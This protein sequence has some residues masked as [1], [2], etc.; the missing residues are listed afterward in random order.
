M[1]LEEYQ[2]MKDEHEKVLMK[3][4]AARSTVN[5]LKKQTDERYH[6]KIAALQQRNSEL[7]GDVIDLKED[8]QNM[9]AYVQKIIANRDPDSNANYVRHKSFME[10]L[11]FLRA[12]LNA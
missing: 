6:E 1:P 7:E 11:Q 12:S 8:L 9:E 2:R 5:E 3:Y 4:A 10:M